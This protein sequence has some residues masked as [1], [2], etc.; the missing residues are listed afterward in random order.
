[1]GQARLGEG[2]WGTSLCKEYPKKS[3]AFRCPIAVFGQRCG[4]RKDADSGTGLGTYVGAWLCPELAFVIKQSPTQLL[5][6]AM[7]LPMRTAMKKAQTIPNLSSEFRVYG[8]V[9]LCRCHHLQASGPLVSATQPEA[10]KG[11]AMKAKAMKKP[12]KEGRVGQNLTS[13]LGLDKG[14]WQTLR[15]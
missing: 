10:M 12:M 9:I 14:C 3:H 8:G 15:A 11:S 6:P 5:S 13:F 4:R 1:M 2:M 7:A